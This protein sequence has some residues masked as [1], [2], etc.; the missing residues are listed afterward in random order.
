MASSS[1]FAAARAYSEKLL[2]GPINEVESTLT[3]G[4]LLTQIVNFNGDRVGLVIVNLGANDIFVA[5][6]AAASTTN[7]IRLAANGGF[8][9]LDVT[10]DFT[11]PARAWF[12]FPNAATSAIYVLE[13]I[14]FS[15][16]PK[17]SN[18][19]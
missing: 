13:I 12:G 14:R 6:S 4:A 11:L 16:S 17:A 9:S 10:E 7:G 1:F 3:V 5:P 8:M 18:T 15:L 2:G 19:A